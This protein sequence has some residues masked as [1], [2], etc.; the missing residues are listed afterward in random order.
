MI[1]FLYNISSLLVTFDIY[2]FQ[3][4][5]PAIGALKGGVLTSLMGLAAF[6]PKTA[7]TAKD[8]SDFSFEDTKYANLR[9]ILPRYARQTLLRLN[10][11]KLICSFY[12]KKK[13]YWYLSKFM[14]LEK[15][16]FHQGY[17]KL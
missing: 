3:R 17:E 9:G 10:E 13:K 1:W 8:L 12:K 11:D 14:T 7:V 5:I 15:R 6:C 2:S 4:L 16:N